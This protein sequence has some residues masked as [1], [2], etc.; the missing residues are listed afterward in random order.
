MKGVCNE[1]VKEWAWLGEEDCFR[2]ICGDCTW[3]WHPPVT[4]W[5]SQSEQV[6]FPMLPA[7]MEFFS[8]QTRIKPIRD[9]T[10]E[11]V[12]KKKPFLL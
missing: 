3:P 5:M 10:S 11:P 8:P 4:P 7:V 1:P 2:N 12:S 9:E 6:G